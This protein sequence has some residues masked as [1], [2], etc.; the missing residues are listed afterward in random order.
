MASACRA[1]QTAFPSLVLHFFLNKRFTLLYVCEHFSCMYA[2][3]PCGWLAPMD[4]RGEG[5]IPG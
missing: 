5:Q 2:C 4:V 3:V 1:C